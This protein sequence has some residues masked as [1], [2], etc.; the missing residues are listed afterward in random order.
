MRGERAGGAGAH[1][2][3]TAERTGWDGEGLAWSG[4]GAKATQGKG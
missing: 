3:G 2:E 4:G 1:K